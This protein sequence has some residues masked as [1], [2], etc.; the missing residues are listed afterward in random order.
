MKLVVAVI[1][2]HQVET[3]TAALDKIEVTGMTLS[4]VRGH[5]RQHGHSEVYRGGEYKVDF[6]PKVRIEVLTTDV[7]AEHV[8]NTI[9]EHARTGK[10]GDGKLWI[11]PVE[12]A[13][14]IRTGE[15]D[16]EA[17]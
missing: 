11:L 16:D 1:K 8:A 2:P 13:M 9:A 6:L 12:T 3:V 17:L 10:I 5:G 7:A 4:E 15:I 14:R